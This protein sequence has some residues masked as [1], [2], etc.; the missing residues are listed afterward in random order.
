MSVDTLCQMCEA[1][2]A[3]YQCTRCGRFVCEAHYVNARGLCADCAAET[4]DTGG[5][6]R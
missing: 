3:E 6:T 1:A 4:P 2:P 5:G